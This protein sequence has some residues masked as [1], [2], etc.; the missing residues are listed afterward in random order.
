MDESRMMIKAIVVILLGIGALYLWL[1]ALGIVE[2]DA[3]KKD[4]DT[5]G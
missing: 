4:D 3:P 5:E 1:V 2:D